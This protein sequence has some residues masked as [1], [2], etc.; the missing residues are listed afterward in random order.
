[1][2]FNRSFRL[3]SLLETGTPKGKRFWQKDFYEHVLRGSEG[4][5]GIC[6]YIILNPV[7]KGLVQH[8]DEWP[9]WDSKWGRVE[10]RGTE[11]I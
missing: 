4:T 3:K 11:R 8:P 6:R 7:R 9:H 1:M 5:A 2:S 10:F